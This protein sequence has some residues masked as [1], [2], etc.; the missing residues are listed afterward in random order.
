VKQGED[1]PVKGYSHF[2]KIR[3]LKMDRKGDIMEEKEVLNVKET[4]EFLGISKPS[5]YKLYKKG[6]LPGNFIGNKLKFSRS[7]LVE[8]LGGFKRKGSSKESLSPT[9]N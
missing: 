6:E 3:N 2:D 9:N 1:R 7:K 5:V 8:F 4:A